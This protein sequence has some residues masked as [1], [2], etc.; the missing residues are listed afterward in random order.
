MR[1]CQSCSVKIEQKFVG[2]ADECPSCGAELHA[3]LNC[4]FYD[5]QMSRSCREPLAEPP[6]EK[7]RAN[8]CDYFDF[9]AAGPRHKDDAGEAAKA[10]FDAL[11]SKKK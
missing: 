1:V 2:R 10:A 5:E 7:N 6:R 3:C 11:F 4:R 8:F 9:D